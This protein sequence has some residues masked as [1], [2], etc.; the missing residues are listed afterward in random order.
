M[1]AQPHV[2]IVDIR[3]IES[4]KKDKNVDIRGVDKM[5]V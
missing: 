4:D 3:L 5:W 1:E 2:S